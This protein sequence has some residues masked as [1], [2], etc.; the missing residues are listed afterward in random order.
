MSAGSMWK[1]CE[2]L[3]NV[4]RMSHQTGEQRW[5]AELRRQSQAAADCL[6]LHAFM[7]KRNTCLLQLGLPE[8]EFSTKLVSA[9]STDRQMH[10][11]KKI[12]LATLITQATVT[13]GHLFFTLNRQAVTSTQLCLS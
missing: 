9:P 7:Q 1:E 13:G 8:A 3:K 6:P 11:P 5:V 4:I 12:L 10:Q 2:S